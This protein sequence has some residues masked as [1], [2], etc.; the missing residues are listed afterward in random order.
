[1]REGVIIF[2]FFFQA[3]DGIRA[4]HVTGVQTCAL[5]IWAVRLAGAWAQV[6]EARALLLKGDARGTTPVFTQ[7]QHWPLSGPQASGGLVPA[8][9][10]DGAPRADTPRPNVSE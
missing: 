4:F 7:Y 2:F 8:Q 1:M 6:A 10:F 9:A 5:P 3:E